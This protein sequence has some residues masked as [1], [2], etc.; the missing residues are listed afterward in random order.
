M[1]E[2]G[3]SVAVSYNTASVVSSL[4]ADGSLCVYALDLVPCDGSIAA[5]ETESKTQAAARAMMALL[6]PVAQ[7]HTDAAANRT[8]VPVILRIKQ[9]EHTT[10]N[11]MN[12][13]PGSYCSVRLLFAPADPDA[14]GLVANPAMLGRTVTVSVATLSDP[15]VMDVI[16]TE[17]LEMEVPLEEPLLLAERDQVQVNVELNLSRTLVAVHRMDKHGPGASNAALLTEVPPN[18]VVT[19]TR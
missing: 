8:N 7:A 17:E 15:V 1:E 2:A 9:D 3:T 13:A 14:Q 4:Q 18:V 16:S 6:L 12:P 5:A 10:I 19:I 11:A